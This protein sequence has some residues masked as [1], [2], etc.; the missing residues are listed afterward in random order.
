MTCISIQWGGETTLS[1][2]EKAS[3]KKNRTCML[4]R[5]HTQPRFLCH[6]TSRHHDKGSWSGEGV[7]S[8][9]TCRGD[10]GI[11]RRGLHA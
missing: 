4:R 9:D 7:R 3:S 1:R 2:A 10:A 11:L 5:R 6:L 8:S